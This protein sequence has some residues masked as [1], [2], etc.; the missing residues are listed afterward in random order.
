L[1]LGSS[2]TDAVVMV[3]RDMLAGLWDEMDYRIDVCRLTEGGHIEHQQNMYIYIKKNFVRS[4]FQCN[5]I[6][7]MLHSL[8]TVNFLNVSRT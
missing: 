2:I 8:L 7:Y 4:V 1:S 3:D 5:K 6:W